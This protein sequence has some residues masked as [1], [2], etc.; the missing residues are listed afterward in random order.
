MGG[1]LFVMIALSL[2]GCWGSEPA[3]TTHQLQKLDPALRT[4]LEEDR[5]EHDLPSSTRPDGTVVYSVFLRTSD[6]DAVRNAQI[7]INSTSGDI[8]TARLSIDQI[9]RA[10]RV[11]AVT[12]I[13]SSGAAT[14]DANE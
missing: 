9:R 12:S 13:R 7:P 14:P 3:L 5:S 6:V 2:S 11:E 4:L 10:A 1:G 8:L